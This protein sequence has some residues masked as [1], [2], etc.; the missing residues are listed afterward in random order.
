MKKLCSVL[1]VAAVLT[2]CGLWNRYVDD[3]PKCSRVL[4]ALE[5]SRAVTTILVYGDGL[6][7]NERATR[8]A[9]QARKTCDSVGGCDFGLYLGDVYRTG[10]DDLEELQ[11]KVLAPLDPMF[12][13]SDWYTWLLYGNHEYQGNPQAYYELVKALVSFFIAVSPYKGN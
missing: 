9:K 3:P 8:I 1:L 4:T 5:P 6:G 13:N 12:L 11:E 2:G 7:E 10:A